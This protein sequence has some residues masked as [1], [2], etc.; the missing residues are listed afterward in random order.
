MQKRKYSYLLWDDGR[1]FKYI[2]RQTGEFLIE[3]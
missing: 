1:D 2:D 3:I